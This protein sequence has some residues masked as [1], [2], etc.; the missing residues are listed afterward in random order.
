M[1]QLQNFETPP[2]F[3]KLCQILESTAQFWFL[4]SAAICGN[5]TPLSDIHVKH[6]PFFDCQQH[7]HQ[8][9]T[10]TIFLWIF[11]LQNIWSLASFL[12]TIC[13]IKVIRNCLGSWLS[14]GDSVSPLTLTCLRTRTLRLFKR[15]KLHFLRLKLLNAL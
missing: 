13:E 5:P 6:N 12:V 11:L 3:W 10:N 8:K 14:F 4:A 15:Q 1:D 9:A 7:F 2:K